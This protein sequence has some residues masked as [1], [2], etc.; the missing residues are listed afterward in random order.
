[1]AVLTPIRKPKG[2]DPTPVH[3]R[4]ANLEFVKNKIDSVNND[5]SKHKL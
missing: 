1:M 3:S 2:N 5:E 4:L